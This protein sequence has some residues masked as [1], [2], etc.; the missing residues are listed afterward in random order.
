MGKIWVGC[1][2]WVVSGTVSIDV[3]TVNSRCVVVVIE[4]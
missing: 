2:L 4:R 3:V 1:F